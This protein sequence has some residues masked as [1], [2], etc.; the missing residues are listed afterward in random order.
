MRIE[1]DGWPLDQART[2]PS[3][4]FGF[5]VS[6]DRD[7][8]KS[9]AEIPCLL[10][11]GVAPLPVPWEHLFGPLRAGAV[12]DLVVI[13]QIGQSI[14]GRIATTTGRSHYI[15]GGASLVHLHRLRALADAVVVG[16]GTMCADD[17]QLTVRHVQGPN[18]ARVVIDPRGRS[19]P[20][21]RFFAPGARKLVVTAEGCTCKASDVEV[22]RLQERAGVFAPAQILASL[23]ERGLKRILIEG[24]A[25]TL[26]NF[27]EAGCLDRLHIMV[28]PLIL[29]AG[30]PGIAFGAIDRMEDAL[31]LPARHHQLD[32]DVLF[33]FDLSGVRVPVRHAQKSV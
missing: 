17:P 27:L 32:E 23:A 20:E 16:V 13:G 1:Q 9:W 25:K 3:H 19:P 21:S 7:H 26:S 6:E 28:A 33:D 8:G 5:D 14:D 11:A 29:G 4:S 22:V 15:N 24:G 18:P 10:R 30:R 2:H 31:R 12:D